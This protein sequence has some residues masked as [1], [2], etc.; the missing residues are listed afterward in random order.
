MRRKNLFEDIPSEMTEEWVETLV[1]GPGVRIE[2]I[3]SRGHRSPDGSWYD[4]EED[5]WVILVSGS[6]TI[7]F[8]GGRTLDLRPGDH[9]DIPAHTKHRIL[10]TDPGKDTVWLAVF[11]GSS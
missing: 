8:E 10:Q 9:L 6:A 4:Q 5:E 2:R 3:I 11:R 1:S 7:S